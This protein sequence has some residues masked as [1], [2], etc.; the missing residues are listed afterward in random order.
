MKTRVI[1]LE[2]NGNRKLIG[3]GMNISNVAVGQACDQT[4]GG[5]VVVSMTKEPNGVRIRK[6]CRF[7]HPTGTGDRHQAF[8]SMV[9]PWHVIEFVG[10]VDE[11]DNE[12]KSEE[13]QAEQKNAGAKK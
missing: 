12:T 13:P 10:E 1:K 9:V 4:W 6:G 7:S 8:D 11:E 2:L 5:G 3:L